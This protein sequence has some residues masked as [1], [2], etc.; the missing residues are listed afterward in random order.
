MGGTS[1]LL[2]KILKLSSTARK[3]L[4]SLA[5]SAGNQE[6]GKRK[7]KYFV[8][9]FS[10]VLFYRFLLSIG[11]MPK[12]S[13]R[14]ETISVPDEFFFDFLRGHLDGDGTFYSYWDPRWR[15]SFMYYTVFGSASKAHI[16]WLRKKIAKFLG[17]KGY[18]NKHHSDPVYQLKYA[19]T[20]SS[21]LLPTLYYSPDILCLGRKRLKIYKALSIVPEPFARVEKLVDSSA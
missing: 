1:V 5:T 11:L 2:Q 15:S 12:K 17:I 13:K 3:D 6:E 19:K 9:Q 16:L 18:I 4:G 14:L 8:L 10:D 20:D 7:K 21:I